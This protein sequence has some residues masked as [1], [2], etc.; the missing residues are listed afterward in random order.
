[1]SSVIYNRGRLLCTA[2]LV[3]LGLDY[4]L[5]VDALHVT[6]HNFVEDHRHCAREREVRDGRADQQGGGVEAGT[7]QVRRQLDHLYRWA[8]MHL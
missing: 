4:D 1:M 7:D 3:S 5:T 6:L 2:C 8:G